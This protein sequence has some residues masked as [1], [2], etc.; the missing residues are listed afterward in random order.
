MDKTMVMGTAIHAVSLVS[1]LMG[2]AKQ[3]K[4]AQRQAEVNARLNKINNETVMYD[5][6]TDQLKQF[7][8]FSDENAKISSAKNVELYSGGMSTKSSVFYGVKHEDQKDYYGTMQDLRENVKKIQNNKKKMDMQVDLGL[9][10]DMT[11]ISNSN[12]SLEKILNSAAKYYDFYNDA[13]GATKYKEDTKKVA[14]E[15]KE[16]EAVFG[17]KKRGE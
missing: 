6:I 7:K 3:A 15:V 13:K 8:S 10:N 1:S 5:S 9:M 17:V 4:N 2:G 12:N 11:N 14:V 16:A